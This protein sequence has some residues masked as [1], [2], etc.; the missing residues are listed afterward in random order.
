M[1]ADPAQ[2]ALD[3]ASAQALMFCMAM[4]SMTAEQRIEFVQ[5]YLAAVSGMAE[6]AI[7][8]EATAAAFAVVA[9]QRPVSDYT[10]VMQ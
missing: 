3:M 8:H 1:S 10:R 7:G 4:H 6:H 5:T 9:Q 2:T